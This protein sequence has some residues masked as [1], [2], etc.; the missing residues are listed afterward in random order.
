MS[1]VITMYFLFSKTV[2]TPTTSHYIRLFY[3]RL[4]PPKQKVKHTFLCLEQSLKVRFL[5]QQHGHSLGI[6]W[7][8]EFSSTSPD[9]LN[10]S[11]WQW[12]PAV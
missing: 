2:K 1:C 10:H 6:C 5:D 7:K 8:F 11:L 4:H 3:D 9:L 12:G